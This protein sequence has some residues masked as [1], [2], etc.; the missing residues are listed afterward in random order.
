MRTGL[1]ALRQ[2]LADLIVGLPHPF[3]FGGRRK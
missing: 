3:Q 2:T 1:L